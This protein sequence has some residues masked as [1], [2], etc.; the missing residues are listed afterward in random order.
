MEL[1]RDPTPSLQPGCQQDFHLFVVASSA[2]ADSSKLET[3]FPIRRDRHS[4]HYFRA[5]CRLLSWSM[6]ACIKVVEPYCSRP[7]PEPSNL[8]EV[9]LCEWRY[10]I[11]RIDM[12]TKAEPRPAINAFCDFALALFPI[13]FVKDLHLPFHKK[14][15]LGVLMSCG[16]V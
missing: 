16:V 9:G 2:Q 10:V 5:I 13:T 11:Y 4:D 3:I 6:S 14:I 7:L 12:L 8:R 1:S 15:V